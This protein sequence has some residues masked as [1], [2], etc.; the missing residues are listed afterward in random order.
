M[1]LCWLQ[2]HGD[3]TQDGTG[4]QV[5]SCTTLSEWGRQWAGLSWKT[6][7]SLSGPP[8]PPPY[9]S[10]ASIGRGTATS[11]S[12][13]LTRRV[14]L[15]SRQHLPWAAQCTGRRTVEGLGSAAP[16]REPGQRCAGKD[17]TSPPSSALLPPACSCPPSPPP[18][19][20]Q[21]LQLPWCQQT[22]ETYLGIWQSPASS[23]LRQCCAKAG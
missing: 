19:L 20:C 13:Y 16:G 4:V 6:P 7:P 14:R 23:T 5:K 18:A 10:T 11:K 8:H 17:A 22:V 12:W 1:S 9:P 3:R 21:Q 15:S 2:G